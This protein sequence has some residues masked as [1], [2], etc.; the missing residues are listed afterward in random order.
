MTTRIPD[1][2]TEDARLA[3]IR[4]R[5]L[6]A[7]ATERTPRFSRAQKATVAVVAA[8]ALAAG[9]TGG[10]LAVARATQ[11]QISYTVECF[12]AADLSS[13]FTTVSSP[14]ATN[15]TTGEESRNQTD[16]VATCSE[17]WRMGLIGQDSVP[18]D[19]NA[20]QFPV[21]ALVG[22]ALADGVGAGFPRGSSTAGAEEFCGDLGLTAWAG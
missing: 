1:D 3:G 14:T 7:I 15:L 22:C 2:V 11:E 18:A 4:G 10:A 8:G 5:V 19:P 12:E 17:M 16:P 9:L 20:A 6:R 21:P 13:R